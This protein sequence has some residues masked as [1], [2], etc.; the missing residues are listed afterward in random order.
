MKIVTLAENTIGKDYIV[1]DVHGFFDI[2]EMALD[3]VDFDVEKE[4]KI[5]RT[6]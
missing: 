6:G 4:V 1:G 2:L 3:A 5:Y